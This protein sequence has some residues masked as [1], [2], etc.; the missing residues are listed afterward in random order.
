[1]E[2]EDK[3]KPET[4]VNPS[5]KYL[6]VVAGVYEDFY[7][8]RNQRNGVHRQLQYHTLEDFLKKS[9]EL[10]WNSTLTSSKDLEELGLEFALPFVRKEVIDFVGRLVA[11]NINPK[12]SGEELNQ[13]S[14]RVLQS[15]YKKWRMKSNDKVEKFW[16]ILYGVVNGTVC[17]YIGWDGGETTKRFLTS[18]DEETGDYKIDEK[19]IAMWNDVVKE[20]VPLEEIYLEK[21]WE[22]NIQKQNKIIRKQEMILSD[23]KKEYGK[24]KDAEFV[25]PGDRIA[26]DSLF[27]QLLEGAGITT[28][29]KIQVFT[30]FCIGHEDKKIIVANGI[31]LNRLKGD[32]VQPNPFTHKMQPYTWAQ[33]FQPVDEKF[34]Y[35]LSLPFMQKDPHKLLNTS[36]CVTPDTK[37]LTNDLRWVTAESLKIGDKLVGFEEY[38]RKTGKNG[39]GS[40]K[41]RRIQPAEVVKTGRMKAPV[42]QVNL[43][44]GTQLK[45]TGN[46]RWLTWTHN[47]GSIVWKRTDE[48]KRELE[49][50]TWRG[51]GHK[52]FMPKPFDVIE[53]DNSYES[54]YIGGLF[55][56][57]GH[58][59]SP[60][61]DSEKGTTRGMQLT[62]IQNKGK[63]LE[64][65]I[66]LL[67]DK[68][69][70]FTVNGRK[71]DN[72]QTVLISGGKREIMRALMSFRPER[73][74]KKW[75]EK[76]IKHASLRSEIKVKVE[77]V[78]YLGEM[79][80]ITLESS[81]KTYIAEGF[82]AHNT[83]MMEAELRAIDR[84][85]LS[86]DIEAPSIVFGEK[87]VI[88]VTD[89]NAYKP[90]EVVEPSGQFF[91]MMN[92]LSETMTS[93]AQGGSA[94][95]IPSRQPKSAREILAVEN[96]KQQMMSSSLLM[97]YD[98]VYQEIMLVLKTALQFYSTGKYDGKDIMRTFTVSDFPLG[99]G[100]VG[101][102]D[103]RIVK[104]PGM[105]LDLYFESVN[106]SIENGR[107]TEIIELTPE[108]LQSLSFFIDKISL[109]PEKSDELERT[110]FYEQILKPMLEVFIPAGVA[111]INKVFLRYLEKAGEH[112]ADYASN[113]VLPQ[114]LN[115][116][117]RGAYTNAM[118][119]QGIGLQETQRGTATGD[120]MQALQGMMRG[121]ESMGG[122]GDLMANQ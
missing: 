89:V 13:Y 31:W 2:N 96:M 30:E 67:K 120:Q 114:L 115:Q 3:V 6:E 105:A 122:F 40:T 44:D 19:D 54:G 72:C 55:D 33:M 73:L 71:H 121:G 90:I 62:F 75:E 28:T 21:I 107:A 45:C 36:F 15:M 37:I 32:V 8:F 43:E 93:Q 47:G 86:S 29:D 108:V 65:G 82:C 109:E 63:V 20:I 38:G 7:N 112:P 104:K 53:Q 118:S 70:K 24:H 58:L 94:Q 9:R 102:L 74:I 66:E 97:Y 23:F 60:Q 26:E 87:R 41:E 59:S 99:N 106:K 61:C 111:D 49:D 85:Y 22:R 91:T 57:E 39:R 116:Q 101:Q 35:G 113:Q 76:N 64:K 34:A 25:F 1:M 68:G 83:L 119:G 11:L 10:F 80:I 50:K 12:I 88:P 18:Y 117:G 95:L 56:G 81:T 48:M 4:L 98:L 92:S 84:P 16:Q 51:V 27:Y 103:V 46:H 110:M 17:C 14:V 77:S 78:A 52:I 100:G 69:F 79:E 5:P 42:Y